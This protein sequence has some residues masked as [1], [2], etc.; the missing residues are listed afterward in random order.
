MELLKKQL[1]KKERIKNYG[2]EHTGKHKQGNRFQSW[3]FGTSDNFIMANQMAKALAQSTIVPKE[4]QGN[5]SNALIAIEPGNT[6]ENKSVDG[7]AAP[8]CG[9]WQ[10]VMVGAVCNRYD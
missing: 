3:N 2:R 5:V 10:A 4:Y 1:K 6:A 9:V 8:L 7:N